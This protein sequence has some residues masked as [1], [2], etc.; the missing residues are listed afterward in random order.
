MTLLILNFNNLVKIS[1]LI[2]SSKFTCNKLWSIFFK[3]KVTN[4]LI[5]PGKPYRIINYA[6]QNFS[7]KLTR[8]TKGMN[9]KEKNSRSQKF[10]DQWRKESIEFNSGLRALRNPFF[11]YKESSK[12]ES[13]HSDNFFIFSFKIN[14]TANHLWVSR[15]DFS[16]E[17]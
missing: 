15:W 11:F 2:R 4:W 7:L 5:M 1:R 13:I 9:E 12:N 17:T 6:K 16:Q 14:F 3:K 10:N 8:V